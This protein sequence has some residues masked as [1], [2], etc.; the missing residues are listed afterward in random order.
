MCVTL[1]GHVVSVTGES[2]IVEIDGHRLAVSA[3]AEPDVHPG[4]AVLVGLGSILA[5]LDPI[6]AEAMAADLASVAAVGHPTAGAPAMPGV[7]P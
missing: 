1:P 7:K 6:E 4:D 3:R 2:A 5:R